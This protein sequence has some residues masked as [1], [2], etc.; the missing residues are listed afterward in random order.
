MFNSNHGIRP[1][2]TACCFDELSTGFILHV[3][4]A[5][6]A[7]CNFT[8][9]NLIFHAKI[10]DHGGHQG[11]TV[12]ILACWNRPLASK[13]ALDMLHWRWQWW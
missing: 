7:S 2:Y 11:D 1:F 12:L 6:F 4:I 3:L 13:E 8:P 5:S 10:D 9:H